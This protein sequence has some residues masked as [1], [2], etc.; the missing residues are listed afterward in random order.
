MSET[1]P[2]RILP[3]EIEELAGRMYECADIQMAIE[4]GQFTT[5][6]QVL[7]AVKAR[8]EAI[9]ARLRDAGAFD[10]VRMLTQEEFSASLRA[11]EEHMFLAR[12]DVSKLTQQ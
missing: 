12:L 1:A 9:N 5:I 6:E 3:S 8:A 11:A 4:S 2:P 7:E 10:G